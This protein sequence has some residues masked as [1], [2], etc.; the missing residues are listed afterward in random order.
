MSDAS[1]DAPVKPQ[2]EGAVRRM[3]AG[4]AI[5]FGA[6]LLYQNVEGFPAWACIAMA[7]AGMVCYGW[8]WWRAFRAKIN[9]DWFSKALNILGLVFFI[10]LGALLLVRMLTA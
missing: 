10:L 8:G 4:I 9:S 2:G 7:P 5:F 3:I 1:P 6:I